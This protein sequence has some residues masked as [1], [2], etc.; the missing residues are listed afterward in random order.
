[1]DSVEEGSELRVEVEALKSRI[2]YQ[3]YVEKKIT[4]SRYVPGNNNGSGFIMDYGYNVTTGEDAYYRLTN[5]MVIKE[6]VVDDYY[7]NEG[8]VVIPGDDIRP[9]LIP[10]TRVLAIEPYDGPRTESVEKGLRTP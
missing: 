8:C 3:T 2:V 10:I 9:T 4:P 6:L 1:M 5:D 7:L